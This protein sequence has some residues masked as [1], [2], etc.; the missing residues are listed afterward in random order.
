MAKRIDGRV[1]KN[2][3]PFDKIIPYIMY[4]R[5]DAM[6]FYEDTFDCAP[7]DAYIKN[8]KEQGININYMHIIIAAIV[9]VLALRPK[10]N[11][12]IMNGKIYARPKV[13]VSFAIHHRL[14]DDDTETTL[15]LEFEGTEGLLTIASA[16]DK[17]IADEISGS[18]GTN[19]TDKVA[20]LV[21]KA[22][23]FLVRVLV[24][25]L[26]WMDTKSIMPK[27]IIKASPFHTSLFIT[28]LKSLGINHIFHHIYNFG[29]TGLFVAMGKEK[30]APVWDVKEE[31]F[32]NSKQL[33][34]GL[35]SDERFCDG[36]YFAKSLRMI[37]K[38]MQNPESL[39]PALEA[40]VEDCE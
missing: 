12:F 17:A 25:F 4:T 37:R 8:K 32:I 1:V 27:A 9:R 2:V 21:M 15:K 13:W 19:D 36:L 26:M 3:E 5:N 28:N 39:E 18:A 38:F 29:T 30:I 22:P 7:L 31:K 33:G 11:R 34:W 40:K 10:L 14:S 20:D 24:R 16:V 23:G 35:V 6:N